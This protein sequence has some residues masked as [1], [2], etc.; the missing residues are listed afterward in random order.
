MNEGTSTWIAREQGGRAPVKRFICAAENADLFVSYFHRTF[1]HRTLLLLL[2]SLTSRLSFWRQ[3][4]Q[5]KFIQ[6]CKFSWKYS[7]SGVAAD[8]NGLITGEYGFWTADNY[9][10]VF[11]YATDAEGKF[12]ILSRKRIP[13]PP[14]TRKSPFL[15]YFNKIV[16]KLEFWKRSRTGTGRCRWQGRRRRGRS[17]RSRSCC[18]TDYH[19]HYHHGARQNLP[20][21]VRHQKR[22]QSRGSRSPGDGL[23]WHEQNGRLLL[24]WTRRLPSYRHVRRWWRW[25]LPA[26]HQAD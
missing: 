16:I 21:R 23:Q 22:D 26:N 18:R 6:L 10:N 14:P 8:E 5:T 2:R 12:R 11:K 7:D 4:F 3:I 24:G 25:W 19:H 20:I 17:R 9:Y 15:F 1:I 13:V